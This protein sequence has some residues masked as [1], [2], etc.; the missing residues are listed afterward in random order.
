MAQMIKERNEVP[1]VDKWNLDSMYD[2]EDL[3]KSDMKDLDDSI[4]EI[5]KFRG[6][7]DSPGT[8]ADM[9]RQTDDISRILE[10]AYT[11]AHLRHD[12]DLR[13][14]KYQELHDIA[15]TKMVKIETESSFIIPEILSKPKEFLDGLLEADELIFA[16]VPLK[17]IIR[18]KDHFL[19]EKEEVLLSMADEA[20]ETP[21][22]AFKML[23]DADLKFGNIEDENGEMVELS[24]GRYITFVTSPNRDLRERAFKKL[25]S[26][27]NDHKNTFAALLEGELKK[28]MFR[29]TARKYSSSIEASL[30]N[31][32][33]TVEVYDSLIKAVNDHLPSMFNY[34]DIRKRVLNI[35][36][37]HLYDVYTPLV[38]DFERKIPYEEAWDIVLQAMEPLGDEIGTILRKARKERW[39]DIYENRGKRSGAYSSG[40]YD[41][42]PYILL[43]Y[44]GKVNDVFTLAHELGHSVHSYLANR[45]QPHLTADYRIF[46]AEVASTVNENLLLHH[47]SK[48]WTS[49]KERAYLVNHHLDSFKGTVFRQTMFAEFEKKISEMVDNNV[50]LTADGLSD[51]YGK[52]NRDH[53]GPRTFLDDEIKL[54]WARIPHFYYNFYVYKYATGYSAATAI[55]NGI[56]DG[57]G[58][59]EAYVN[60]L[61]SGGSKPPIDLLKGA[62]VDLTTPEPINKGLELFD[63]LVIELDS[64]L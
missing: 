24:H 27:F 29:S 51:I 20:L 54:E 48:I 42:Q 21:S 33:V 41:S 7:L 36:Q 25:Y 23:N 60:M 28:R 34:L 31:D 64:A 3:W 63:R 32:E 47:L 46:V 14:T 40:C 9:I 10:K 13:V 4:G 62:G 56:V 45:N 53:F 19:S 22:K 2:D 44:E 30:D 59:L 16:I 58:D 12:E 5:K 57:S 6:K 26:V 18:K 35:D 8:I 38:K 61:K 15:V 50:P 55:S 37:V 52:L 17:D 1:D 11:Y 43:N 49:E 39:I